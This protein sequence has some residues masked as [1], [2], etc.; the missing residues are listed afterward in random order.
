M[1][2]L[3]LAAL[4]AVAGGIPCLENAGELPV[5]TFFKNFEYRDVKISPDGSCLGVLA[6]VKNRVGLAVIDLKDNVANWAFSDKANDLLK[7]LTNRANEL[8]Y[9]CN[10][11]FASL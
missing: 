2:S 8:F 11:R 3:R 6:P 7:N 9:W 10:Q 4:I 5:E 1:I